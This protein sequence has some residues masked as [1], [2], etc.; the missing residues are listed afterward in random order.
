MQSPIQY[1]SVTKVRLNV[2]AL[3]TTLSSHF[4]SQIE[5]RYQKSTT[6]KPGLRKHCQKHVES[7]LK[8]RIKKPFVT[9]SLLCVKQT[10][11]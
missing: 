10:K 6:S 8:T 4:E 5:D 1:I 11:V 2:N 3:S 9:N 7:T